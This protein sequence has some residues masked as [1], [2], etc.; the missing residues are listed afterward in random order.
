MSIW[1][2]ETREKA[3]EILDGLLPIETGDVS[4]HGI[5]AEHVAE[6]AASREID[7]TNP[8]D[9]AGSKKAPLRLV[10][11]ALAI[12]VAPVMA[13][14]AK[15]YGPY[16]WRDKAVKLSVYLEAILRHTYAALDGEWLD[17]ESGEP[18]IAH[19]GAGAGIVL[20]AEALGQLIDDLGEA[21][22]AA[23]LL[24][25]QSEQRED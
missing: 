7:Q 6:D 23:D 10:P 25:A 9:I 17:P 4:H 13:L 1:T 3:Q 20:D 16:N 15:K 22:P 5:T 8:K 19:I 21:G 11:P 24:A 18:H 2:R 14:G 12:G